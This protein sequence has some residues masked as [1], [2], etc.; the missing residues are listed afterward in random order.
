MNEKGVLDI[1]ALCSGI[2]L[3]LLACTLVAGLG[4]IK[5]RPFRLLCASCTTL[6]LLSIPPLAL[7]LALPE[8]SA[9]M[10]AKRLL[11]LSATGFALA[12]AMELIDR[13][14]K[15]KEKSFGLAT[16]PSRG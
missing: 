8:T 1:V 10:D 6:C 9:P 14:K 15:R 16:S 11:A 5:T 2:S 4:R 13:K 7:L 3:G 12:A